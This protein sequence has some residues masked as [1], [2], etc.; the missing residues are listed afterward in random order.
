MELDAVADELYGLPP[1]DFTTARDTQAKAA[2]AAG[3]RELAD[4]IGRLRRP[5]LAAWASNLLVRERPA[6]VRALLQLGE[7][8]RQAHHDLDGERLRELSVRQH[9]LTFALARQAAQLTAQA[10][11]SIGEAA[12][13]D[14]QDTLQ[15]VLADPEA[16][17]EWAAG[18]LT[19]PLSVPVGFPAA[20]QPASRAPAPGRASRPAAKVTDLDE[21]RARR[22][23]ARKRLQHAQRQVQEA[24]QELRAREHELAAAEKE[25]SRA[26]EAERQAG[27]RVA[28]L[29]RQLR[30]AE[31]E[32]RQARETART[33]RDRARAVDRATREA[34]RR[35]GDTEA[36]AQ[37]LAEQTRPST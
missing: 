15:A 5:T 13:Q 10:G 34:R 28:D 17:E 1:A 31:R 23:D 6:E 21:A 7:G 16:A 9:Q 37:K 29:S 19:K 11:R 8:L 14:V 32:Q 24:Q 27:Q 30:D 3:N 36:R 35:A 2:R 33:A 18:R 20:R 26:D 4:E 25:Q 12:R 22:D